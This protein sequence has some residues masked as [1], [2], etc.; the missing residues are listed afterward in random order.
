MKQQRDIAFPAQP[1]PDPVGEEIAA[2]RQQYQ[3]NVLRR[4]VDAT[5]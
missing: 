1:G 2:L 3:L 4:L 5:S